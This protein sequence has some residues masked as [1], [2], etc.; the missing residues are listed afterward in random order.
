MLNRIG[1]DP[2]PDRQALAEC[3]IWFADAVDQLPRPRITTLRRCMICNALLSGYHVNAI[4]IVHI[5]AIAGY[6]GVQYTDAFLK[7]RWGTLIEFVRNAVDVYL[8]FGWEQETEPDP[9]SEE[10]EEA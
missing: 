7:R 1:H 10:L 3:K 5:E 6:D 2:E 9:V 8:N 4:C